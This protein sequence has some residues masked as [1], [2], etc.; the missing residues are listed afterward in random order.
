MLFNTVTQNRLVKLLLFILGIV[1][2]AGLAIYFM[3][4][5]INY[6]YTPSQIPASLEINRFFKLGGKVKQHSV[7]YDAN[8]GVGF[9]L[10]DETSEIKV[11]Y[12]GVLPNLFQ[13]N[14][15]AVMTGRLVSKDLFLA[16]QIL[17]KHDENYYPR[18]VGRKP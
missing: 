17:A 3:F 14:G 16:T 12:N 18:G 10:Y 4:E 9:V 6:F 1:V 15:Y 13:E 8:G 2:I 11:S 7:N 5:N